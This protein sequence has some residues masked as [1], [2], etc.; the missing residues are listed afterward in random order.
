[1]NVRHFAH[2]KCCPAEQRAQIVD[3]I[4]RKSLKFERL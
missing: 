3:A 1:M 4:L 2:N